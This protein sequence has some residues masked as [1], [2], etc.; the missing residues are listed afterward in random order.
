MCKLIIHE[1]VP[2]ALFYFSK[3]CKVVEINYTGIKDFATMLLVW[4]NNCN[5]GDEYA[6]PHID[7]LDYGY[8]LGIILT[9]NNIPVKFKYH[10]LGT[11]FDY[12][13]RF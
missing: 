13:S 7:K 3:S 2:C 5:E 6:L 10:N 12:D 4:A 9:Y 1:K 8:N 11:A